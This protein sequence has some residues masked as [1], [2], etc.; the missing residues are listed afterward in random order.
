[1]KLNEPETGKIQFVKECTFRDCQGTILAHH[2]V[3][4]IV[5]FRGK[6]QHYYIASFGGIWFDEA[7]QIA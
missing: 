5:E 1:M 2:N 7:V 4:D 6:T 3:G